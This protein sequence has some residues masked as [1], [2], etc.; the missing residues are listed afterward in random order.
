[1]RERGADRFRR[2]TGADEAALRDAFE[3]NGRGGAWDL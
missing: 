3:S 2:F 1:V